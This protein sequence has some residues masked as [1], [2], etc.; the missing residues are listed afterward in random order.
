MVTGVMS[1]ML[2]MGFKGFTQVTRVLWFPQF[3]RIILV[4]RVT[5]VTGDM[6]QTGYINFVSLEEHGGHMGHPGPVGHIGPASH[7][8]HLSQASHKGHPILRVSE[9]LSV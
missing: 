9:S 4:P 8:G 3:M 7:S 2:V 6:V 1:L 5:L